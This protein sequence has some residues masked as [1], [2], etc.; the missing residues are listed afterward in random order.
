MNSSSL[1]HVPKTEAELTQLKNSLPQELWFN[2]N[3]MYLYQG[4]WTQKLESLVAFQNHFEAHDTDIFIT[5][6]RKAGT[7]WL[8]ALVYAICNRANHPPSE[9]PLLVHNPHELVPQLE[10]NTYF[11]SKCPDLSSLKSPRLFGTHVPYPSLPSSIKDT[12]CKIIYI[13]RNPFDTLVSSLL[14][15]QSVDDNKTLKPEL[16]GQFFDMFC[17]GRI[18]FGPF[19]DHVLGYWK[20]SL[21]RPHK[22]LFVKYED[23]KA[24]PKPHL[25]KVAEFV[26]CPFSEEEEM[27]SVIDGIVKLCSL[28]KLKDVATSNK[29]ARV[30]SS[31]QNEKFFRKGVVG[32]WVNY[33][34]PSMVERLEKLMQEKFSGSGLL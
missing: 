19:E 28:E 15:Y 2:G 22:V 6:A 4:F 5:S 23:L 7:T 34:T 32:D 11:K 16:L 10:S 21:E 24:D 14:F 33:L 18:P 31:I 30:Y 13:Y 17:E 9:S 20:Q 26:G 27:G 25:K 1:I 3:P 8:K 29:S 12:N